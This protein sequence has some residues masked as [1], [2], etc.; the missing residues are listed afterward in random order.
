MKTSCLQINK[1]IPLRSVQ[2]RTFSGPNFPVVGLNAGKYWPMNVCIR[3]LFMQWIGSSK[4]P[5]PS[6]FANVKL[7]FKQGSGNLRENSRPSLCADNF[8]I[9]FDNILSKFQ[10]GF[11]KGYLYS[12]ALPPPDHLMIDK[13]TIMWYLEYLLLIYPKHLVNFFLRD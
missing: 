7:V 5:A 1:A 8:H 12:T 4:F 6:K 2:I 11:R 10:L 3:T 13:W 9:N